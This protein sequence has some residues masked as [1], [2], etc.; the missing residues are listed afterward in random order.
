M[1]IEDA[2]VLAEEV[3][4]HGAT[5][6]ALTRYAVRRAPRCRLVQDASR[7][8]GEAGATPDIRAHWRAL[9]DLPDQAQTRIDAVYDR[10]AEPL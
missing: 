2:V 1:G 4:Q 6:A 5:D 10:L 9:A 8:A 3:A 7:A